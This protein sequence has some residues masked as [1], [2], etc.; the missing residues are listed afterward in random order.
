MFRALLLFYLALPFAATPQS[1]RLVEVRIDVI[2]DSSNHLEAV[3]QV[4]P[5]TNGR[6]LLERLF[7]MEYV[8][9][10]KRFVTGIAGFKASPKEKKFWLLEVDGVAAEVG[11]AEIVIKQKTHLRWRMSS[12]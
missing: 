6:E 10:T 3:L 4:A 11:I 5:D 9:F 7:K 8:D 12:Y 2:A 1:A